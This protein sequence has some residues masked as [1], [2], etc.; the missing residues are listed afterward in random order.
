MSFLCHRGM[1]A[2]T[3]RALD[4]PH[5]TSGVV[6]RCA[7][8]QKAIHQWRMGRLCKHRQSYQRHRLEY[9]QCVCKS[10]WW[11]HYRHGEGSGGGCSWFPFMVQAELAWAETALGGAQIFTTIALSLQLRIIN[12]STPFFICAASPQAL[13]SRVWMIMQSTNDRER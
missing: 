5:F 3:D 13:L 4:H 8:L 10:G 1:E 12:P 6:L 7:N 11:K 9:W 2:K